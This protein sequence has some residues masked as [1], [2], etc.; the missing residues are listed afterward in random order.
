MHALAVVALCCLPAAGLLLA[1]WL[2]D[3][4]REPSNEIR[5]EQPAEPRSDP[6]DTLA[7]VA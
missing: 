6:D 5:Q 7:V 4:N 1:L 2:T 3:V